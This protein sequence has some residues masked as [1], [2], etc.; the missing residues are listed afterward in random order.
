MTCTT[1]TTTQFYPYHSHRSII[2][3]YHVYSSLQDTVTIFPL[4]LHRLL[5]FLL[6]TFFLAKTVTIYPCYFFSCY[7]LSEHQQQ[8]P[9]RM[10]TISSQGVP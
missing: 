2:S 4:V 10:G 7:F 8:Q 1:V 9:C 3:L 5:L 6:V